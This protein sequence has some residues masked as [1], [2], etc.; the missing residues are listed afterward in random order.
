M[1]IETRRFSSRDLVNIEEG[2]ISRE[3]FVND[4][5][6]KQELEQIFTRTWLFVGHESQV[7]NPDDYF[8]SSMGEESVLLTRDKQ[9]NIHVLLNTC[10]HRGM[11]VCRYDEGNVP[12]FSCPYHGWSYSTD[13]NLV[14]VPGQLLGVPH[15]NDMYQ[16]QLDKQKWGL[17]QPPH[18]VNYKG[19]IWANWDPDAPSFEEYLGNMK[20]YLDLLLDHRD[21]SPGGSEV[22]GGVL[23]WRFP[24]NWKFSVEN[25]TPDGLH[26]I[27]H[28][29]VEMVG[30]GPGGPGQ[31]RAGDQISAHRTF[32]TIYFP[33][34][35]GVGVT[36]VPHMAD[37]SDFRAFP[38]FNAPTGPVDNIE[39][40]REYYAGLVEKRRKNLAGKTVVGPFSIGSVFPNMT[41]HSNT[42]PRSIAVWQPRGPSMTECWR[43]LLVD[44]D[45][46]QEIKD[47][48]RHHFM[49]YS[50]PAGMTEQDDM[51]N[52]NYATAASRGTIA[53]RYPYNYQ[54]G[55]GLQHQ[56]P[57]LPEALITT[58]GNSEQNQMRFYL[59]WARFMDADSW[60]DIHNSRPQFW[61]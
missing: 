41:F 23:K 38:E 13:G 14:K 3:V 30:I 46:P 35:H 4:E 29:S 55:L 18:V 57:G 19:S 24:A 53:R 36:R 47:L 1:A 32:D 42:W 20:L 33:E 9:N 21:G 31:T 17:I 60:D 34:G 48:A 25:F 6:Y 11:K 5:I 49:R 8:V 12:V 27:S 54:S 28:R 37:E 15:Y 56:D 16:A 61:P 51:E 52:W 50:G 10:R 59:S 39:A 7:P 58:G 44:K 40:A 26:T 43:W 2:E 45:A 22:I